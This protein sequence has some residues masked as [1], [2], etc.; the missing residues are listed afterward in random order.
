MR[1]ISTALRYLWMVSSIVQA[2]CPKG[3]GVFVCVFDIVFHNVAIL[4]V[5]NLALGLLFTA[6]LKGAIA[7]NEVRH[8]RTKD[9]IVHLHLVEEKRL[10]QVACVNVSSAE[11][12]HKVCV[13]KIYLLSLCQ[14]IHPFLGRNKAL[15]HA[16]LFK[17]EK[18]IF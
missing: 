6:H 2:K 15:Y 3:D 8:F 12:I 18:V 11:G 13:V 14:Q 9:F 1:S 7:Y 10:A 5:D 4:N 16:R 17:V